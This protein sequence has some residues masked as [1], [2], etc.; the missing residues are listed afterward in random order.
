MLRRDVS[1]LLDAPRV[2]VARVVGVETLI[3]PR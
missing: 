2:A 1:T 3:L